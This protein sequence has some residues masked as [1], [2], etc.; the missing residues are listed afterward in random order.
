MVP[1]VLSFSLGSVAIL[2]KSVNKKVIDMTKLVDKMIVSLSQLEFVRNTSNEAIAAELIQAINKLKK[3]RLI[4]SDKDTIKTILF[5]EAV[6]DKYSDQIKDDPK[7]PFLAELYVHL[8]NEL[9]P[10]PSQKARRKI[11]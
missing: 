1:I 9:S 4:I 6:F 8:I 3:R 7:M 11:K 5:L 10:N 2:L